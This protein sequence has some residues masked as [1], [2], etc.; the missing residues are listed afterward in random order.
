MMVLLPLDTFSDHIIEFNKLISLKLFFIV[1]IIRLN[2][3]IKFLKLIRCSFNLLKYFKQATFLAFWEYLKII[4][5]KFVCKL[6]HSPLLFLIILLFFGISMIFSFP[7]HVL[8]LYESWNE[9][10][11]PECYAWSHLLPSFLIECF[12]FHQNWI[13]K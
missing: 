5:L 3:F 8:M 13:V 9:I 6:W 1:L 7:E 10:A 11:K 4:L 12:S 2:I